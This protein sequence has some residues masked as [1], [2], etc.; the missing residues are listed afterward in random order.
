M[1]VN[2]MKIQVFKPKFRKQT[3]G[4]ATQS[5]SLEVSFPN[6]DLKFGTP[7]APIYIMQLAA[8]NCGGGS[9]VF[10]HKKHEVH[11]LRHHRCH[12]SVVIDFRNRMEC[13]IQQYQLAVRDPFV[14]HGGIRAPQRAQANTFG[15]HT[16]SFSLHLFSSEALQANFRLFF[17][18][19]NCY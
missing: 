8:P 1:E 18:A 15:L 10:N 11:S 7:V 2:S 4:L 5:F 13:G 14:K 19:P 9:E 6:A 12:P 3:N 17:I 16:P